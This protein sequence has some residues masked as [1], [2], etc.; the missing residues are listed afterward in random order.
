MSGTV[1]SAVLKNGYR[2]FEW[3][4]TT[5]TRSVR[6]CCKPL[7]AITTFAITTFAL[8][9]NQ[10]VA[11]N[12]FQS[13][14]SHIPINLHQP[15]FASWPLCVHHLR[16]VVKHLFQYYQPVSMLTRRAP[17]TVLCTVLY[18]T[19]HRLLGSKF[20]IKYEVCLTAQKNFF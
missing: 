20:F 6:D 5:T 9:P 18:C 4:A 15:I 17:N 10:M 2:R 16:E 7:D 19:V 11:F 12:A 14:F 1:I 13:L 8:W 3:W